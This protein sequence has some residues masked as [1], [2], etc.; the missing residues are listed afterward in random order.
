MSI[1]DTIIKRIEEDTKMY[2]NWLNSIELD[3]NNELLIK[4]PFES[5]LYPVWSRT[6]DN[7]HYPLGMRKLLSLG[8]SGIRDIA[9][10]NADNYAGN[11]KQYL[12]LIHDVYQAILDKIRQS[13][14]FRTQ[15][16]RAP[17]TFLEACQLYWLATIFRVGTATVGRLDQHLYPFYKLDIDKGIID[18]TGARLLMEELINKYEKRG[19]GKGDTLQNITLGGRDSEGQDQTNAL[20]YMILE[21]CL[22]NKC[23]EPKVNVRL[24]KNSSPYLYNLVASIQ[25]KG[26]GNCTVFNDDVII[27][28]LIDCGRPEEIACDYC[29]DGCSEIILDGYGETWFRYIDCVKAIEHTLFNGEENFLQT[30][31][32]QYYSNGQESV[33]VKSPVTKGMKTGDF[34]KMETFEQFYMAYLNQLKYQLEVILKDPY[35]SDD[36]PMRSFT[37]ATMPNVLETASEPYANPNCYHTYGL[38]IG[39]LGTAVNSLATIKHLVY[40]KKMIGKEELLTALKDNFESHSIIRQL[41][42]EVP[43]FGNDDNYVDN[44]AVDIARQYAQWVKEYNERTGRLILPG[45]YNHLFHHT[46]YSV[47]AT[48]DGRRYGDPIGEHLSPTPGTARGGPTAVINSVCKVNMGEQIFGSTLHLSLPK[49]SLNGLKAPLGILTALIKTFFAQGGTVLNL[50]VLNAKILLEAQKQPEKYNDLMVRVWGFSYYF[51]HLS[52]EMQDHVIARFS[53]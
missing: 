3:A 33:E 15:A 31:Q 51:T 8:F 42:R 50:S 34:L 4:G 7:F 22:E 10:R 26:T 41:C 23:L 47:G 13:A 40:E 17:Q 21:L 5:P 29:A 9:K 37:A 1:S 48:P 19:S 30:K 28:G 12:L 16:E 46:A 6:H 39:S 32:M 25:I 18:Q 43:K 11:Q 45:L 49:S 20:T 36:C 35:N 27:G 2:I 53:G 38:F 24:H 52:R 14:A 44:L